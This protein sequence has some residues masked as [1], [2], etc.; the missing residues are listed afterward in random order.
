M[1]SNLEK[2]RSRL[3][4][5]L[6]VIN[7]LKSRLDEAERGKSE[8]I[9]IVGLGCRFPGGGQGQDAYWR[10]LERGIDAVR[11]IPADRWPSEAIGGQ[12]PEVRWAALLEDVSGFDAAFF[13]ISPREA[14]TLDPQQRLLLEVTWE[15]L[16]DAGL[17]ADA[18]VG[19]RAGVF[20][21]MVGADY[22]R[23]VEEAR[24]NRYD[25]YCLTGNMASTAAGRIS[26]VFGLQGPCMTID[27]ACS[28]SLVAISQACQSLRAGESDVALAGGVNAIVSPLPMAMLAETQALSPDGRCKTLDARANGYVRGEG[29]G[30]VVLKRLSDAL[31]DGDRIRALI[32]GWAINQDGRS[33][34]LTAPNVLSQQAMLRQALEHAGLSPDDVG[35]IELHGTGTPLGDPIEIEALREVFGRPRTDGSTCVLGAVKT[36]FGHLE[37]AAGVAGLIKAVLALEHEE[38]PK[39]LH[40]RRL[41]PRISLAGTP[42]SIPTESVPWR[43]GQRPR[44]AGVNAFGISGTNVHVILEEAPSSPRNAP[45][46][47][48]SEHLLPLSAKRPEGLAALA[49]AYGER[50][51]REDGD[52][53]GDIAFTAGARRAHHE[54]RLAVVGGTRQEVAG[55]LLSFARGKPA[56]AVVRGKASPRNANRVVFVFPGQGSQ[57]VG[58]GRQ[59]LSKEP[60]FRIALEACDRVIRQE[61][62]FSVLEELA[63]D[64][65]R[66]RLDE[67]DV[68]Q[69][70]LFAIEV[71]LAALWRAWGVVPDHV[72]G[73]SMGEVAA[74]HV[75]GMLSLEDAARVIC[76]R[77]RLLRRV[78]GKGAMA[79]VELTMQEAE[80]A[81]RGYEERVGVAVSNGPRATVL[82]GEPR[83]LEEVLSEL[84]RKGVFCRRVKVDVASHSPQM[85][86]L[87]EDLVAALRG[88]R[89]G[90]GALSMRSTVT[91]EALRGP[92]LDPDY[93]ARNLRA[94]V[95]FSQVVQ[96]LIAEG[97]GLF[98]EISPHPI[99]LPSI[100]ENLQEAGREGAALASVRRQG[101]E[102]RCMLD[103]LGAMYV[104][105]VPVKWEKIYPE[106]MH[107]APLPT[108]PWQH[109]RYWVQPAMARRR[110]IAQAAGTHPLLGERLAL[111][112]RPEM[113]CWQQWLNEEEFPYIADHRVQGEIVFPG[114]GLVEMALSAGAEVYGEGASVVEE[115]A[116]ERM[117]ALPSGEERQVQ[118][119][120]VEEGGGRA[121]VTIASRTEGSK[122]WVQHCSGKL[123][124][125][126]DGG[127]RWA[128]EEATS[129]EARCP[130][131]VE[132]SE[133]YAQME[134]RG[135]ACGRT[136]QGM[137]RARVGRGE[138]AGWV[139]LPEVLERE[140]VEY[141]VHPAL[142]DACFQAAGWAM[143]SQVSS[144][145]ALFVPVRIGKVRLHATPGRTVWV[146]ARLL[147]V[148]DDA[149][150]GVELALFTEAGR[151]L[152]EVGELRFQRLEPPKSTARGLL[153]ECA[154]VVAWRPKE[155]EA[156]RISVKES[157]AG[158]AWLLLSDVGG[159]G[160]AVAARLRDRGE[161]C[162]E[163]F[164]GGGYERSGPWEHRM[165]PTNPQALQKLLREAFGER[166]CKGVVHL[167][168]LDSAGPEAMNAGRLEADLRRG[169][170]SALRLVQALIRHGF[171]DTPRL[172]L[173][174]RGAQTVGPSDSR[175][176][177]VQAP[178]WGLGRTIALE[179]P[180]LG[181]TRVDLAAVPFAD[182]AARIAHELTSGDGEDQI[183][184]R[185]EGRYV[186]RLAHASL[187]EEAAPIGE[188]RQ[189]PAA[190]RP[191]QVEIPVPGVLERL[192]L[193][194]MKRRPPGPGEVEIEVEAAGLNFLD[195]L[196]ALGALPG[197]DAAANAQGPRLGGEC[198][199][200]IVALGEGVV[201]LAVGQ[202][203]I[204][205]APSALSS[206]VTASRALVTR[207]PTNLGWEEAATLP[208]V[209]LTA[210]HAL[211]RVARLKKGE[212]VLIHAGAGGV[213][214]AAIQWAQHVG[215]EIFAT[216]G[217]DEKRSL[218]RSLGV[219]H[220][221]DSRS[222]SFVEE[223][224][225]A[226]N[227]EGVDVVLNSLSGEFIEASFQ[228][229]RDHGRFVEIGKRDY[230]ENRRL[231][232][233]PFLK[234]LTFSL[235]D[236]RSMMLERPQEV[237][238]LLEQLMRLFETGVLRPVPCRAFPA[239][240]AA[241]AFG[242]M[243]QGKH[244]GKIAVRMKDPEAQIT[245]AAHR[246]AEALR[247]DAT[248]LITG[249]LGGLG[250]SLARWMVERGAR[251]L[252]LV[253]R[254]APAEAAV[255]EI[256]AMQRT[257]AH[258]RVLLADVSRRADVD[259]LMDTIAMGMPPL[260]GVVHAAGVLSD[261]TLL[262]MEE[263]HL[264]GPMAPKVFGVWNLHEATSGQRLDFFVLYSSS[265]GLLG[266]PGQAGY[267]AANV[268]MDA[269]SRARRAAGLPAMS[270]QW[271]PFSGV[272]LA[273]TQ[274]NRGARLAGRGIESFSPGE[275]TRLFERLLERPY[276]EIGL[277]RLSA[278]WMEDLPHAVR[279]HF[280]SELA[281]GERG[282]AARATL[283]FL[284]TLRQAPQGEWREL[285]E[286]H[287]AEQMGRVLRMDAAGVDPGVTFTS[288]GMDSLMGLELRNRLET[289]LGIKL[290]ATLLFAY[291]TIAALAE[292][293]LGKLPTLAPEAGASGTGSQAGASPDHG[294]VE[295]TREEQGEDASV[296]ALLEAKL[297]ALSRYLE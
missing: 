193:Q 281:N 33:T 95:R 284:D 212:R 166:T 274:Q 17:R 286:S 278:G 161:P 158:D 116:F 135:L 32:R 262:E 255:A 145:D 23:I 64:E 122:E 100:E 269:L 118:V 128:V 110:R 265:S 237:S 263:E 49:L 179:H 153:E 125:R 246:A 96:D 295:A 279:T 173:I 188:V 9:A 242:W 130:E 144:G 293:L 47:E 172:F 101:E 190:G 13:G 55:A 268:F 290:S 106:P 270:I 142:L 231:G 201:D 150:P 165:D 183:A 239:S 233:R 34:G 184:L 240:K 107:H 143:R 226:T 297:S 222:L 151:M 228:L 56:T 30:V 54:H 234:N 200:R 108:Y 192:S 46:A 65:G 51:S 70:L 111:S 11:E 22:L 152:L 14:E 15:A 238:A 35:Y 20:V 271:G 267:A 253:G 204:A 134:A 160:R 10:V 2:Y 90:A 187:A 58:M 241:D 98:L 82:S 5:A 197:G 1:S 97:C 191:F 24:A 85:D 245:V 16:E 216:A 43:R 205:V 258:V 74:A 27:T 81:L 133:H 249:G 119:V 21:G 132:K 155:I 209:F 57:W 223:T 250:L 199:G 59:L 127:S 207:T 29:C 75:A 141:R 232:L 62:G 280:L 235:V 288:L 72:V 225:R 66:S 79:L 230:Y 289:S 219:A 45:R 40:F 114:A 248:Y 69:P 221:M 93:W 260:R 89:P 139:R 275:G 136:F 162:V 52:S 78:S 254:S 156:P 287:I 214:M 146:H 115:M 112:L 63:A 44:R 48:P 12:R 224:L 83:A 171:R 121:S 259:G 18:M 31:R 178:V 291:P 236:L 6:T 283:T 273:A 77:S 26:F 99:L 211:D 181:C 84:E 41:N 174:T 261:R 296:E 36:N 247:G 140:A 243:A 68:V 220:V 185:E 277:L 7:E 186:A 60:A 131:V 294:D 206:F 282:V 210:Y 129:V 257:G 213:G 94:P 244:I 169:P 198:A 38:I 126:A 208:L 105:G 87:R 215:A 73:H 196:V 218:L 71:A 4:E 86:P 175:V 113:Y 203:V 102:R 104:H 138:A 80:Q 117:L 167:F 8:P 88:I 25:A 256:G 148:S 76:R 120:L 252:V 285:V 67:I 180:E 91:G 194:E 137:E 92:E 292:H 229:L 276:A 53:L 177:V 50:L 154:Y 3:R 170:L 251:H 42:F 164:A 37:G 103:A 168:S 195:V 202:A 19:A 28:S 147:D 124:V 109:E 182:E 266:S 159:V 217:S 189:E 157:A 176:S 39:N 123:R 272:G 264:F 61:S 163:A 149:L 227:G